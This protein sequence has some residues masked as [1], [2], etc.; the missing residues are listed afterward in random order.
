VIEKYEPFFSTGFDYK[1]AAK[2]GAHAALYYDPRG[3]VIRTVN[4]DGSEQR[5][6]STT[7]EVRRLALRQGQVPPTCLWPAA[8]GA[9]H[10]G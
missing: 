2:A 9:M 4:P 6:T 1:P 10:G 7:V 5:P 8:L 3:Q